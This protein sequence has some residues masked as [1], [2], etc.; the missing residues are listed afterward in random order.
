MNNKN[1]YK[2]IYVPIK[3]CISHINQN[4][5]NIVRGIVFLVCINVVL[6]QM[7]RRQRRGNESK[8]RHVCLASFLLD[9]CVNYMQID[10][11]FNIMDYWFNAN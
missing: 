2:A 1:I 10:A 5:E 11:K 8:T 9:Y 6:S 7:H 4:E 3:A